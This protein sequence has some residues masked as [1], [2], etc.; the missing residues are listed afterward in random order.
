M[1]INCPRDV[2]SATSVAQT[3]TM[4]LRIP[5]PTPLTKRARRRQSM[6]QDTNRIEHHR[7][8]NHPVVIHGRTLQGCAYYP[9]YGSYGNS[10]DSPNTITY[11]TPQKR[12]TQRAEIIDGHYPTLQE[13]VR[14]HRRQ[15]LVFHF[16]VSKPHEINVVLGVVHSG[17]HALVI[18]KE[19]NGQRSD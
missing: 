7:T 6:I 18:P 4:E 13:T 16:R 9:P 12:T 10:L 15:H 14:H 11:P 19:E 3:G 8:A 5:V 17:H 1:A 2:W